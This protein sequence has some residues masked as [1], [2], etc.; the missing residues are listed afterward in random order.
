M[1]S[2][3]DT[4]PASDAVF[5]WR[6]VL[7]LVLAGAMSV[8]LLAGLGMRAL[9]EP[10]G[11]NSYALLAD[12][13]LHGRLY[14][15]DCFDVDCAFYDGRNWVI[16]PP[17]PA[18]LAIPFVAVFGIGF[19]GFILL[20]T[21]ATVLALALWWRI[22][23]R[24]SLGREAVIWLVLALAFATPLYYVTIRADGVWFLAQTAAFLFV[25]IAIHEVVRGGSLVLAGAM[26]GLAML[27][28][29][30]SIFYLPFLFALALKPDEPLISFRWP[31][32]RRALA[33]GLPVAAALCVYFLYNYV[34]FG[35]P[36]DTGYGYMMPGPAGEETMVDHRIAD[37]GL[38]SS[39]YV[40]F[41]AMY[42]LVQGFHLQFGG[43]T[44]TVPE[45][46]DSGGTSLL[47]ASPFVL[48]AVFAPMRRAVVIGLMM[49]AVIAAPMLFY[50]SNGFTQY[51]AQRYT[52]DW[53]P[54]L[55]VMLAFALRAPE[56]RP[57]VPNGLVAALKV[58]VTYAVALNVVTMAML[59]L[60]T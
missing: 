8:V 57:N 50:H 18:V 31:H 22:L 47:A 2:L 37:F 30:M 10:G 28:R 38:F 53:L 46:M 3:T 32:W 48:L 1:T 12:A 24:L 16:F 34:R 4:D 54:I 15:T 20:A 9:T 17:V 14:V 55:F 13:F 19:S 6:G 52:L 58:L 29:Q 33:L 5:R 41:N 59:A 36:M 45:A 56:V 43:V 21:G 27:C 11:T 23:T 26:I 49:I 51:N 44:M 60:T 35:S 25:T 7:L 39:A 40:L 42:L